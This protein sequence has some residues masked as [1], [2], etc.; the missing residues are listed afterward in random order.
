M[1][2]DGASAS[3]RRSSASSR[4]RRRSSPAL[5][6]RGARY[7]PAIA[8]APLRGVAP[9]PGPSSLDGR[10]LVGAVPGLER[11]FIAAGNGPWGISTG[12][13]DGTA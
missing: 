9:A 13:G 3:A 6:E 1:T 12:P 11:A 5:R 10:P 8:A 2:A 7:V 4:I